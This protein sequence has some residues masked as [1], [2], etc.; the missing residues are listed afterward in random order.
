MSPA[1]LLLLALGLGLVGWL[2]ARSRAW[3]FRARAPGGRLNSLPS[4]HAWYVALW[5]MVPALLFALV[6]NAVSPALV[7]AHVLA[8]PAAAALPTFGF[9]RQSMLAQARAVAQGHAFGVFAPEA[10][11]LVAPYRVA[12]ARYESIGLIV[13]ILVALAGG[14]FAFLRLKPDFNA[15]TRV[16]RAVMALLLIASLVAIL[17][18]AGIFVS[19]VFETVRFFGMV[20]PIDFL[21]GTHWAPD[22]MS[23][24]IPDGKQFGAIPLFWGTI[25]IGAIIAMLVAIP[26]GLMSAIYL[27]Q[28][29]SYT[30]R[31]VMKPLLEILAGVPTVVYGYF[32]ALTVAP[33]VRDFAQGIGISSASTESAVAAGLVMGVMIIPFVSSM[34]DDSIAAVPQSLRDGSLAMGAT[35]AETIRKVLVPAA[36]PGIVA[37]IMLAISRAIGETMIVVMA[38]GAS[39]NLT[40]NPFQSM[41]TVTFQIVAMLTGEG[42]FDHP[43]TLSAFALGM[44]L[45]LVTLALNFIALRVVKRYREAYE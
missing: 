28:Y 43:A 39:A 45:F 24:G 37:G 22:P 25:Y 6:W 13:T 32:A 4:F 40:A 44:V 5:V 7:T 19:L 3:A 20:S 26:L 11:G 41:T 16:E 27:T 18:T 2:A 9:E 34:A 21:F 12:L 15:R 10:E 1:I 36:L 30:V 29:A 33:A 14:I 8:D 42:S 31:T 23:T 38:A 35:R 17:T